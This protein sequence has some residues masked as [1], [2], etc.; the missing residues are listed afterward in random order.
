MLSGTDLQNFTQDYVAEGFGL[1]DLLKVDLKA[2]E[3]G[4][5]RTPVQTPA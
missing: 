4:F 2:A 3:L 1:E 5:E